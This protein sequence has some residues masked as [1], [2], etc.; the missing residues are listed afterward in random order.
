MHTEILKGDG[1]QC[2]IDTNQ[3]S[4]HIVSTQMKCM[5]RYLKRIQPYMFVYALLRSNAFFFLLQDICIEN[6]KCTAAS[7]LASPVERSQTQV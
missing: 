2:P 1:D 6:S 3:R 7:L 4:V 5:Y